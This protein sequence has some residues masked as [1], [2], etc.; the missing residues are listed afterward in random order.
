MKLNSIDEGKF[1]EELKKRLW[2]QIV[3]HFLDEIYL[4]SEENA[5]SASEFNT[6]GLDDKSE[7]Y[8]PLGP[9]P[10]HKIIVILNQLIYAYAIS[11][12]QNCHRYR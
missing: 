1:E 12:I 6:L 3:T 7:F 11:Q 5:S 8:G 2:S 9:G 4:P 10:I